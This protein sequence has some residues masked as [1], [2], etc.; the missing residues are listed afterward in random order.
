MIDQLRQMAIFAKTI[1]HG[2]FRKAA[3]EL[4]L[5]PSVVSHHISQL[6]ETLGTALIYRTTRKLT[7][8][9]EGQKLLI[10]AQR[11]LEVVE[12]ELVA[13]SQSAQAPSGELRIT[14]PSVLSR[15]KLTDAFAAFASKYGRV[16]LQ[17]D[18]TDIRKEL[19]GDGFD[20]AIRMRLNA[21]NSAT[22]RVLFK[23][24]RR[25]IAAS[26][27]LERHP[28]ITGPDDL[29]ALDWLT[30][31]Q[32]QNAP[33]TL[34][35]PDG[36]DIKFKPKFHVVSNDAQA[37]YHLVKAGGGVAILPEF[38]AEDDFDRG[39]VSY[40][41]PDWEPAP[42]FVFANWPANAPRHGLIRLM[43]DELSAGPLGDI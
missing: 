34:N 7:L 8:T 16:R 22:T 21:R 42:A 31:T 17:L 4:R 11:M 13:L 18:F 41:L 19:V 43:L 35:G 23:V 26:G 27:Y 2:S 39:E 6:E 12:G 37:L 5:S 25:L 28:D 38:L 36:R 40:V 14:A 20:I 1:D 9:P 15:S 3:E 10:A 32:F 33:I 24:R 30:L 29:M